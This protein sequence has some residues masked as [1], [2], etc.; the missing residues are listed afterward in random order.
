VLF[1]PIYLPW[2]IVFLI[3]AADARVTHRPASFRFKRIPPVITRSSGWSNQAAAAFSFPT[4]QSLGMN[5]EQTAIG[6]NGEHES[7]MSRATENGAI[8]RKR[9]D[10]RHVSST[11]AIGDSIVPKIDIRKRSSE[12]LV[13]YEPLEAKVYATDI[14]RLRD[15]TPA[16]RR[17][18]SKSPDFC[19][20]ERTLIARQ[21]SGKLVEKPAMMKRFGFQGR[22]FNAALDSAK[23]GID[24]ARAC[25]QLALEGTREA[26]VRSLTQY[27][28][29][30]ADPERQEELHGRRRRIAKLVEQEARHEKL[31]LCPKIFPGGDIYRK[32]HSMAG[33]KRAFQGKR[34]DHLSA[35]GG[36]DETHGN[37]TLQV[38]LGPVELINGRLWQGF[39]LSHSRESLGSFRLWVSECEG[40]VAGVLANTPSPKTT[41]VEVW[42]DGNGKK[43]GPLRQQR[44]IAAG[45]NPASIRTIDRIVTTGRVGFTIDLRRRETGKWY[46]HISREEKALPK[47]QP[48]VGWMGV[49]LNCDS[50]AHAVISMRDGE[51]VLESYGKDPF[52]AKVPSGEV[53]T[54]LYRAINQLVDDAAQRSL[55]ICL[56]YLDFE[57][58]KRW[59]KT[60]L[61]ALLHVMPYRKIRRIFERRCLELGVPFRY[62]PPKYSSLLGALLSARWP[63]LGRDQAAGAVL[64]LRASE[65]GNPWLETACE[66]AVKAD[67][68]SLRLN[69]KGKYGHTLVVEESLPRTNSNGMSGRQLDSPR[70]P[71]EP[72]LQWQVRCGRKVSGA[73]STLAALRASSLRELRR[74]AKAQKRIL[75]VGSLRLEM[76]H[77]IRLVPT[78]SLDPASCSSLSNAA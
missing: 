62:V 15:I 58:C 68:I 73:F 54:A 56:E 26:L 47:A 7:T 11:V 50:I 61:G 30:E 37:K 60:K 28:E 39:E 2:Q 21:L 44:M 31:A 72:A 32:Q 38:T 14:A 27:S 75:L 19:R 65:T 52:P 40:L 70:F 4:T 74:A 67:R 17:F 34:S 24:S 29:A 18:L 22:M 63:E 64:A 51:P 20:M 76:P 9:L 10:I 33:W 77:V 69:A 23:G 71:V 5:A 42:F 46:V 78:E 8:P 66:A 3:M 16:G 43:I 45:E 12:T 41:P 55:G 59:L 6:G 36:A 53:Q 48:P 13:C 25:A 35:N 57:H 1:Q 49:D